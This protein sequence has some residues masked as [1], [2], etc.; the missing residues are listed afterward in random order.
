EEVRNGTEAH[1]QRRE[2]D[3]QRLP[4]REIQHRVDPSV[5]ENAVR[6]QLEAASSLASAFSLAGSPL[7][8]TPEIICRIWRTRTPSEI[9]N[10]IWSSSTTLVTL[11]TRPPDVTTVSPRR[12]FFTSSLWSFI[13]FCCGRRIRKYMMTKI[14]ANGSSDINMLLASPPAAAWAYAGVISIK[15]ILVSRGTTGDASVW[16]IRAN[17]RG[18]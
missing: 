16:P 2:D 3:R 13:F 14:S 7:A 10:S 4:P 11:P 15:T 9:S 6:N 5:N 1:H 17:S 8:R 18:L 12:M